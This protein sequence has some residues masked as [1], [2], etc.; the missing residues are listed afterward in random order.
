MSDGVFLVLF[1]TGCSLIL[2]VHSALSVGMGMADLQLNP[3]ILEHL[4]KAQVLLVHT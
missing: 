1:Q 4:F 2:T 3:N